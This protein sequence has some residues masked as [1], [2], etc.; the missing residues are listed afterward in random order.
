MP[1][2][3]PGFT[4]A[5]EAARYRSA[6]SGR[7]VARREIVSQLDAQIRLGE[8]R[9]AD[10][11][12]AFH[13]GRIS[14]ATWTEQMS[15]GLRRLH[16][17]SAA[18]GAGGWD[19]LNQRDFG[20]VGGKLQSDYRRLTQFARDI[21]NGNVSLAQ[22]LNRADLYVGNART[23]FW[24]AERDRQPRNAGTVMIERRQL[25][26]GESCRDCVGYYTQ[27][28][29]MAGT[30]PVPG[31]RSVCLTKCKCNLLRR[32]VPTEDVGEWLGTRR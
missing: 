25:G 7:F 29:A 30:L 13:E 1:N 27:G 18:Q 5:S 31:E 10:L 24:S 11:T 8:Q 17:Q 6:S 14:A 21:E 19:R 2:L 23:Q 22:A 28:W 3:L 26:G 16:L 12:T 4:W 9:I 32:E 15:T 20:R